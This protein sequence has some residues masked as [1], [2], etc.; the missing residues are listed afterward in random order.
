[1]REGILRYYAKRTGQA[2]F[3]AWATLTVT[4]AIIRYMPGGPMDFLMAKLMLGSMGPGDSFSSPQDPEAIEA[5]REIAQLYVNINPSQ[6]IYIQYLDWLGDVLQGNLGQSIFYGEPVIDVMAPVI[7]WTV[8][9][10][11]LSVVMS[12]L[13]QIIFGGLMANYEGSKLDSRATGLFI[14]VQSIPYFVWAILLLFVFAF[15]YGV[16]P[17]SGKVNPTAEVGLNWPYVAGILNHAALP[18]I[19]LAIASLGGGVLAM[20]ANSIQVLGSDYVKNARL[21]GLETGRISVRY[22]ARNALLPMYTNFLLSISY[23]F[24]GSLILETIFQYRGMG[25]VMYRALQARD[26]P[27]MMGGFILF[28]FA[29]VTAIY[30]ADITYP[31]VDPRIEEG[32]SSESF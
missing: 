21:R 8:F 11:S 23:V 24:G 31:L 6:P 32:E 22:I 30:I 14:W 20:R 3:T 10:V 16:F 19:S 7:P 13:Q 12:F 2:L 4:F 26:F 28:T 15:Q 25:W 17:I 27:L 5:F 29:T 9:I 1:M 18:V